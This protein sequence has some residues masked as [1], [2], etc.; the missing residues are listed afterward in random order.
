MK[1]IH[2]IKKLKDYEEYIYSHC[3]VCFTSSSSMKV[4]EFY[5]CSMHCQ[6]QHRY[7][8]HLY[9]VDII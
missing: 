3:S 5:F 1:C 9:S 6:E 4:T 8:E 2:C 7:K